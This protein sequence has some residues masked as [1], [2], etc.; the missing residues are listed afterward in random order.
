MPPTE[1]IAKAQMTVIIQDLPED[2]S[3]DEI[4]RELALHRM[5]DRGQAD[6]DAGNTID[7]D[8]LRRRIKTWRA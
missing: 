1:S 7:T 4:L 5:I 6:A 8:E 3:F 2:S